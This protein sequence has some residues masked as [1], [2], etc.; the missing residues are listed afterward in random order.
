MRRHRIIIVAV[1]LLLTIT[2][3]SIG[4]DSRSSD[5]DPID[6]A[7]DLFY[8]VGSNEQPVFLEAY[9]GSSLCRTPQMM[10]RLPQS[11]PVG[12]TCW[13]IGSSGRPV[14]GVISK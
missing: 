14:K 9:A 13:C 6:T 12:T 7:P 3:P 11:A 10:C 2:Q 1:A 8:D 4:G 5:M